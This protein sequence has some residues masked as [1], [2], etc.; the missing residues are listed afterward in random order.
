MSIFEQNKNETSFAIE[1]K[2]GFKEYA[3]YVIEDR[4]LPDARDGLKPVHRRIIWAMHELNILPG[5]PHKKCA[6]IVGETTGK[7]H[8]HAGG[9]YES[10]V[11]LG[12]DWSLRYPLVHPQGNFGS[13]D[14]YPPAAMRYTEARLDRISLELL[15]NISEKVVEFIDNFDEEEREPTVLPAKIPHLLL[16]G[17]YGI[18]V[19]VSCNIPPHNLSELMDASIALIEK[20]TLSD[21]ELFDIVTA[22]DFPTGGIIVGT[23][24][25]HKLYKTGRGSLRL[26]SR[27][28]LEM[29]KESK[30]VDEPT[31]VITEIPYLQ[32]KAN[33][34]ERIATLID[35]RKVRGL[36]DVKDLSEDDKIVRIEL[37]IEEQYANDDGISTIAGQLFKMTNLE[38]LFHARINAFVYGTPKMLNLRQSLLVFLDFR[39]KTVKAIAQEEL[40]KVV[41]RIHILDGLLI[42]IANIDDVIKIIRGSSSRGAAKNTL[43]NT[44]FSLPGN[45]NPVFLSETQTESILRMSLGR[46]A[47]AEQAEVQ[48]EKDE[49]EKRRLEL[50]DIINNRSS[51]LAKMKGE[52]EEIKQKYSKDKR[53]TTIIEEDTVARSGDRPILHQRDMLLTSTNQGV[54]RSIEYKKFKTQG[55]GGKGVIGVDL[56]SDEIL[57]DMQVV[58]NLDDLLLFTEEGKVFQFPA[59]DLKEVNNRTNR[60]DPL[61]FRLPEIEDSNV[62]KIVNVPH[63]QFTEDKVLVTVTRGGI[64]KRTTLDKYSNIRRTGII[65]LN[66]KDDDSVVDAFVTDGKSF[67]FMATKEGSAVLFEEEQA[68]LTGR[69]AQG[70]KGIS[71]RGGD[72]VVRAFPIKKEDVD[73]TSILTVTNKGRGKRTPVNKYR[74]TNRGAKGVINIRLSGHEVITS[75]PVPTKAGKDNI[76]LINSNGI[77]IKVAVKDIRNMGRS[78]QGVRIMRLKAGETILMATFVEDTDESDPITDDEISYDEDQTQEVPEVDS[79]DDDEDD[80][81]DVE[82]IE[83]GDL[84]EDAK[85]VDIDDDFLESDFKNGVS[86]DEDDDI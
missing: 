70:V 33:I 58:S 38:I 7:Y 45:P 76:S 25:I 15:E 54:V 69:V 1:I 44:K 59:Y 65:A 78:T 36:K 86:L 4:A 29:P 83:K 50:E 48:N 6:R 61:K 49:K 28:H 10:L 81:D 63:D 14:G 31:I 73:T 20:P 30:K 22:P 64:V 27:Y 3:K 75:M 26:R 79:I 53:R 42:A 5:R 2:R 23:S 13:I 66:L 35:D 71:L 40:E 39:E 19:G 24:G 51:L 62:V 57:Y 85:D 77:L 8:P 72:E 60:G 9:V 34:V 41:A 67:I 52:F 16:N 56:K 21:A 80:D 43:M 17:S 11:R 55:R 37:V 18:A 12:Q 32:N 84:P 74:V 47:Q 68:R 46:L 82:L